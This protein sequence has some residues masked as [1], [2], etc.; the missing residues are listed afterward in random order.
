MTRSVEKPHILVA[1]EPGP[2]RDIVEQQLRQRYSFDYE[3][4]TVNAIDD[5]H[6][7]GVALV[8]ADVAW[9][10]TPDILARFRDASPETRRIGLGPWGMPVAS[11]S[12]Q[13]LLRN[14]LAEWFA[15]QPQVLPDEQFHRE[16]SEFLEEWSRA[17]GEIF[18]IVRIVDDGSA[19]GHRLRDLLQRNNVTHG[20]YSPSSEVGRATIEK[21]GLT[22]EDLPAFV[23]FDG[24]VLRDPSV[25][26]L[27]DAITGQTADPLPPVDVLVVGA[28]PAGLA[29]ALYSASEG[30]SVAVLE[31]EAIGGQ[32]GT[33]SMIRNYLGFQRGIPGQQLASR[34]FRQAW[35]FGAQVRFIR[36]AVSLTPTE[37]GFVVEVSDGTT[38]DARAV[39][40]AQGV[41]YRRLG[42]ESLESLVGAGVYYGAA[43]TEAPSVRGKDA[44]VVG[45]GNSAGQAAV[46]LS[47]FARSVTVL[48]RGSSLA[49]SM[50]EYLIEELR[51]AR[52]I[53]VE[54]DCEIVGGGGDRHLERLE[55]RDRSSGDT[56]SVDAYG[57]F[58]LIGATAATKW[59]PQG[60]ALDKWGFVLTGRDVEDADRW[61]MDR[62][63]YPFETSLPGVFAVGDL[64]HGSVKRVASAVGEGSVVIQSVHDYL[65][66][67][68][69]PEAAT[70]AGGQGRA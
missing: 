46:H 62:P 10:T 32:A 57:L 53:I 23:L 14:G 5:V 7:E 20:T 27:A 6:V 24:K 25:R 33:T 60:V 2:A 63:T 22:P 47:K 18:E 19:K 54:F 36:E 29:A 4:G 49:E 40:L 31:R 59:L 69:A 17:N 67:T 12:L 28:G 66:T 64:R 26:D 8:L 56:R 15:I 11:G 52:N 42:I 39:V 70:A 13:A 21:H 30:L 68:R 58:V 55:I 65:A 37:R 16:I 1:M 50:S 38:V 44:F 35:G 61:T 3:I 43:V 51:R 41:T 45:G 48:V 34:A 9:D